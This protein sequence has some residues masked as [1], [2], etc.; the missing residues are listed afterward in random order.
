MMRIRSASKLQPQPSWHITPYLSWCWRLVGW[1][2]VL[3]VSVG[4]RPGVIISCKFLLS[5]AQHRAGWPWTELAGA[6]CW[7]SLLTAQ[8]TGETPG[9]SGHC[10]QSLVSLTTRHWE[11]H[12]HYT[13][14]SHL[15][16]LPPPTFSW[17]EVWCY[18]WCWLWLVSR[19]SRGVTRSEC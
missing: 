15:S 13:I 14:L 16:P 18:P 1:V 5:L 3:G 10:S 7:C 12:Q 19:V 4:V 2:V 9:P 8:I 11:V 17:C 6:H